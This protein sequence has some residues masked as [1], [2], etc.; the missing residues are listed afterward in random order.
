MQAFGLTPG[1]AN[2]FAATYQTFGDVAVQQYPKLVPSYPKVDDILDTS[3]VQ[4]LARRA[5]ATAATAEMPKYQA[6]AQM[7]TVVSKKNFA[8]NFETGS[9]KLA[10]DAIKTLTELERDLITTDLLI[11]IAGHTDNT[12]DSTSNV[13]LSKARAGAVKG[14]LMAQ[15]STHFP[16]DRFT[17]KGFGDTKP[18]ATNDTDSGRAKNRRV[19]VKMGE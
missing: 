14:W 6:G 5:P 1:G 18:V 13:T 11:E 17:L 15:S 10:P 12:G 9:A 4:D 2:L 3:Y 19:E 7:E 8:I 16:E